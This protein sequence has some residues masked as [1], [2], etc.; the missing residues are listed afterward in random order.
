MVKK[1]IIPATKKTGKDLLKDTSKRLRVAAYVRVSTDTPEQLESFNAQIGR[2]QRIICE[3]HKDTW[4]FAGIFADTESGTT[5]KKREEFLDMMDK[6]RAG[7]IDLILVKQISRFGRNTINTL[8]AIYELRILGVE[9]YFE[10]DDIYSSNSKLDFM[11]TMLSGLAQEESRQQSI[12]VGSGIKERL[13]SGNIAKRVRPV[14]GYRKDITDKIYVY[15]AEAIPTRIIFL[16]FAAGIKM[17]DISALAIRDMPESMYKVFRRTG[18]YET[19]VYNPRYKGTVI[20][21]KMFKPSYLIPLVKR[22][23]GERPL[24]I[25]EHYH[26]P[27]I[28]PSFFDYVAKRREEDNFIIHHATF[29]SFLYCGK[30]TRNLKPIQ[31]GPKRYLERY[32]SCNLYENHNQ[33]YCDSHYLDARLLEHIIGNVIGQISFIDDLKKRIKETIGEI[34]PLVIG[35]KK[36][37]DTIKIGCELTSLKASLKNDEAVMMNNPDVINDQTFKDRYDGI[38]SNT[39]SLKSELTKVKQKDYIGNKFDKCLSELDEILSKNI[40]YSLLA[41]VY[42]IKVIVLP[43][44]RIIIV[45]DSKDQEPKEFRKQIHQIVE[46]TKESLFLDSIEIRHCGKIV[47]YSFTMLKI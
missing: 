6:C 9:V 1:T 24:Y 23:K 30:C 45:V 17:H 38:R 29:S 7:L 31:R 40:I 34:L 27:L 8:Q 35:S 20:L 37:Y 46:K 21:Q 10:G 11:L 41:I 16:L 39:R 12:R 47:K 3:E 33:I 43:D 44:Y 18:L 19:I 42:K 26:A 5:T 2:Y 36:K 32:Y 28:P 14:F 22:N 13:E 15:E 4:E 25:Y